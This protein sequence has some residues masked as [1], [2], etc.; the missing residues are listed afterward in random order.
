M[1]HHPAGSDKRVLP[2][3]LQCASYRRA[4]KTSR[5]GHH[6]LVA[7]DRDGLKHLY[8]SFHYTIRSHRTPHG[9]SPSDDTPC[10]GSQ[11]SR[12]SVHTGSRYY[13][14][15]AANFPSVSSL[16]GPVKVLGKP[17]PRH[18]PEGSLRPNGPGLT[19][20]GTLASE[21]P[22]CPLV[23]MSQACLKADLS[24]EISI[25][26]QDSGTWLQRVSERSSASSTPVSRQ[27]KSLPTVSRFLPDRPKPWRH[28]NVHT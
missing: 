16:T 2:G 15:Y 26:Y 18:E 12:Y 21:V 27:G 1:P 19:P 25:K 5:S 28:Y 17:S 8:R 22:A 10:L 3:T 20:P 7:P 14:S 24:S 11:S 9:A 6:C 13:L 23:T 4:E